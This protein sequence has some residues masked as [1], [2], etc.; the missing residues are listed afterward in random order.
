M[1]FV[2]DIDDF[3][4][5]FGENYKYNL[6]IVVNCP[7]QRNTG[8]GKKVMNMEKTLVSFRMNDRTIDSQELD[9]T[10]SYRADALLHARDLVGFA[11]VSEKDQTHTPIEVSL[12]FYDVPLTT[13]NDYSD[14]NQVQ[15]LD[16]MTVVDYNDAMREVDYELMETVDNNPEF[17]RAIRECSM[18]QLFLIMQGIKL[19]VDNRNKKE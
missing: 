15:G 11:H 3:S 17:Q 1:L 14:V 12:D 5:I 8:K 7:K 4:N 10:L 13:L 9:Y 19:S 18:G 6:S 16:D 2:V